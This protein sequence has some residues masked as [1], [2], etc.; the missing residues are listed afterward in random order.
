MDR[1][2][3]EVIHNSAN[4]V[5]IPI[6]MNRALNAL[7]SSIR[8]DITGS[9]ALTVRQWLRTQPLKVNQE[10]GFRALEKVLIG[11]WP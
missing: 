3:P 7:Y 11:E 6:E 1:F 9:P 5:A 4:V 8:K 10:F 2:G